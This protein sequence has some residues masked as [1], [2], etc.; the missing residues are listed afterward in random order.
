MQIFYKRFFLSMAQQPKSDLGRLI[1]VVFR[2]QTIR[3][4]SAH[5]TGLLWTSD[6]LAVEAATYT[7]HNNTRDNGIRTRDPS[8]HA[9]SNLRHKPHGHRHRPFVKLPE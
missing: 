3:R 1:A 5:P 4:T 2:S 6:Q 8:S 7:T 9:A